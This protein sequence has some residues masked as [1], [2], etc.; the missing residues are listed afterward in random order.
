MALMTDT[1]IEWNDSHLAGI[2]ELARQ[3]E[4]SEIKKYLIYRARFFDRMRST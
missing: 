1:L 4:I 3:D 2:K